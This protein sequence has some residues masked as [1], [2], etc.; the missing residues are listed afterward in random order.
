[1]WGRAQPS[2]AAVIAAGLLATGACSSEKLRDQNY[3]TDLAQGYRYPDGGYPNPFDTASR[4]EAGAD[5]GRG[6][7]GDA[8]DDASDGDDAEDGDHGDDADVDAGAGG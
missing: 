7:A 4:P 1:M 8:G 5:A 6:D 3:G 2:L